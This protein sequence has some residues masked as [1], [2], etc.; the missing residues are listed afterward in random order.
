MI[1]VQIKHKVIGK[2]HI[3]YQFSTDKYYPYAMI[4]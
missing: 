2:Y 1:F 3:G 4:L